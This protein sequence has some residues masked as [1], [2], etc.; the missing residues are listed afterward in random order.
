[1]S[2]CSTDNNKHERCAQGCGCAPAGGLTPLHAHNQTCACSES[3]PATEAP[4][5]GDESGCGCSSCGCHSHAPDHGSGDDKRE[6]LLM[7]VSAV[8]FAIGMLADTRMAQHVPSWLVIAIFYAL[9]YILCGYDVLRLGLK[10]ILNK[11]FFNEFTLMGGATIAAIALG[12][13][14]EAVGVM[15][16]YRIGEFVQERAAGH[17]RR[18]VKALLA[19]RPSIAHQILDDGSTRDVKPEDL[20]PGSHILV[21][22]GEKIPLDG[23]VLEGD[24]QVDTSPLTGESVPLRLLPGGRVHAGTI[25][26]NGSLRIEVTAAFAESSIAR[27]LEMVE[28]AVARKAPTERFITRVA[29]W[30]TPAVT[31]L[32]LLVAVVPPILG[33]GAFSEWLYRALVLLVISC[34][35]ALLISIPLGYFGGIGAASRRGILI[36]GGAVLDSLRDIRVA[37]LDKTGTLTEGVFEVNAVL[38]APGVEPDELLTMA[39]LAESRSNHPIARSVMRAALEAKIITDDAA[40]NGMQEIPGKGVEVHTA[41]ATLLAGNA[42]LME[43]YGIVPQ[44]VAIPGSVVQV[45]S[46]GRLLGALVVADRLKPQSPE[47]IEGLRR[48]GVGTIAMLTGDRAEQA[49]PVAE[50]LKLDILKADLLPEDKAGALEAIGP[51]KNTLFVGDG[52]ND[53]PVLAT[54]GVGVAMGGLG[55]EAAIETADVVILDDNPARLPELLRIARRTRTIVWQNIAMALGIK[56]VF[57]G[58]GILGLSGLWEAVFADVGVALMAVLNAARAGKIDAK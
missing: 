44:P 38:P 26:L 30:Y 6:L 9:P 58:L 16:F 8:L 45:A 18:S 53:A 1:M 29:R 23:T 50:R 35:C 47:A 28:N 46:N 54:A 31:G 33:F 25:N 22:P 55:A 34:P 42:A 19:A 20:G 11:D 40:I 17:S 21:R 43:T 27:I 57:M 13:L 3:T 48:M 12:E 24:S 14:P 49:L 41:D 37:A 32:A 51:V 56:S 15:L 5:D 7:G 52:I 39:A 36:K 4:A 2:N 10:S